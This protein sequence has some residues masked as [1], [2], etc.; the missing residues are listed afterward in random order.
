LRILVYSLIA[1]AAVTT[2]VSLIGPN[3]DLLL[4]GTFYDPPTREFTA[5]GI[6]H[7]ALL[8]QQGWIAA[9]TCL[10]L[11]A[12]AFA[13]F[14]RFRLP[15]SGPRHA[16]ALTLSLIIGPGVLVNGILKQH[17]GRPR[18]AMVTQFGGDKRFVDWW[19]PTG[20]CPHNCSFMSGESSTAGWMFGPAMLVPAPWR[21]A[22]IG[23]AAV[24]TA[25]I[26]ILRMAAGGHFFTD[27]LFGVLTTILVIL[28]IN[29]L[30][31][32]RSGLDPPTPP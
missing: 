21:G 28:A 31:I 2:I 13:K 9:G 16:I 4:A 10:V 17:S 23:A 1:L 32:G 14:Q 3:V 5:S 19:N 12:L 11:W 8:R 22:A 29:R 30:I 20:T 6:A 18:P 25:T 7:D 27:V 26:S 24:Y 15:S